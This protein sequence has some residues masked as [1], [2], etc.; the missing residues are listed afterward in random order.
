VLEMRFEHLFLCCRQFFSTKRAV[1]AE[2][3]LEINRSARDA[4]RLPATQKVCAGIVVPHEVQTD[5]ARVGFVG[6][7]VG[8]WRGHV[9]LYLILGKKTRDIKN[10]GPY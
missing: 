1:A 6:L 5:G 9:T 4:H 10:V 7:V 3:R 8:G 2:F